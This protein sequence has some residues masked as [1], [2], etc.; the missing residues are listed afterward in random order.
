MQL[1]ERRGIGR[2]TLPVAGRL[3][4]IEGGQRLGHGGHGVRPARHVHPQVRVEVAGELR[5][6]QQQ[7]FV[8]QLGDRVHGAAAGHLDEG[9]GHLSFEEQAGVEDD[10]GLHQRRHVAAGGH[11]QVRIDALADDR[12]HGSA[13]PG[14]LTHDVGDHAGGGRDPER[15]RALIRGGI[16]RRGGCIA[17]LRAVT[18]GGEQH[19]GQDRHQHGP[20]R[21]LL[22]HPEHYILTRQNSTIGI[23]GQPRQGGARSIGTPVGTP[24]L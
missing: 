14:H 8:D 15:V 4:R 11:V 20:A 18:A 16:G 22:L 12:G 2:R 21:V 23:A 24:R 17:R 7:G 6:L 1:S 19:R 3:V 13:L 5:R 10:V 9:V